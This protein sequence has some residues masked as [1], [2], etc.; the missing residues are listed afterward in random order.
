MNERAIGSNASRLGFLLPGGGL[1]PVNQG[2]D[3]SVGF[4]VS[5]RIPICARMSGKFLKLLRRHCR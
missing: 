2:A 5:P 1:K 3:G 4:A